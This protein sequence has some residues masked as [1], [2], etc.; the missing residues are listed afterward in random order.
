MLAADNCSSLIIVS[1]RIRRASGN[2]AE[3][4]KKL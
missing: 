4:R 2:R 3:P 1:G